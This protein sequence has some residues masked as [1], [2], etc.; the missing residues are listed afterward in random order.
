MCVFIVRCFADDSYHGVT[1]TFTINE[2]K[3]SDSMEKGLE[4]L[5]VLVSCPYASPICPAISVIHFKRRM[6]VNH[7]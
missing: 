7:F 6:C 1:I 4:F 2:A 3:S 5:F